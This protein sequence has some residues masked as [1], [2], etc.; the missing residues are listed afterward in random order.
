MLRRTHCPKVCDLGIHTASLDL[1]RY[2]WYCCDW[3]CGV[4]PNL[5][6]AELIPHPAVIEHSLQDVRS[7]MLLRNCQQSAYRG[8]RVLDELEPTALAFLGSVERILVDIYPLTVAPLCRTLEREPLSITVD[9]FL[10]QATAHPE[11]RDVFGAESCQLQPTKDL[12]NLV[13]VK[14]VAPQDSEV[15]IEH[16][17]ALG[18]DCPSNVE[19]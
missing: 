6:E 9:V 5:I 14:S 4:V 18:V 15:R 3:K 13:R 7:R 10:Q 8:I 1:L 2:C 12:C 16:L 19:P 11:R 17:E